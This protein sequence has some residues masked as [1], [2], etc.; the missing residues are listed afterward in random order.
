MRLTE[1]SVLHLRNASS[2]NYIIIGFKRNVDIS[3]FCSGQVQ[4]S[5]LTASMQEVKNHDTYAVVTLPLQLGRYYRVSLFL[6]E[7]L[8]QVKTGISIQ[9]IIQMVC[10]ESEQ[11][12][13]RV[14]STQQ[15]GRSPSKG[16]R[17]VWRER[18]QQ[19]QKPREDR[20]TNVIQGENTWRSSGS[21]VRTESSS[22]PWFLIGLPST[23]WAGQALVLPEA[24]SRW[25][26]LWDVPFRY[27][28]PRYQ[29][30]SNMRY[31]SIQRPWKLFFMSLIPNSKIQGL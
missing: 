29:K 18:W 9:E 10:F 23:C 21:L 16:Q 13:C 24:V 8:A 7:F 31:F 14:K 19:S 1:K 28:G 12:F 30:Q 27:S 5:I 2:L 26:Q 25:R 4:N 22:R 11:K 3:V 6:G 17:Q 15:R 20:E